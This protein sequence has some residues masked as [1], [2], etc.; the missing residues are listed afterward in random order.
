VSTVSEIQKAI[1]HLPEAEYRELERWWESL[2]HEQPLA[3]FCNLLL[4][5]SPSMSKNRRPPIGYRSRDAENCC[6]AKTRDATA[7]W[8]CP[9]K[10]NVFSSTMRA[11][12]LKLPEHLLEAPISPVDYV[13]NR[14][15][16]HS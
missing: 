1:E 8:Y 16:F 6:L 5:S 12:S 3:S 10:S 2:R 4:F 11:I 9:P 14:R 13:V 15:V 7:P